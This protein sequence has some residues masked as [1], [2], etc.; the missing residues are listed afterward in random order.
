MIS[1]ATSGTGTITGGIENL[2]VRNTGN[3]D[4]ISVIATSA[5]N[6]ILRNNDIAA[7][8]N[9][10]DFSTTGAPANTLLLSIDGNTLETTGATN[11]AKFVGQII[12]VTDNSIAIRSFAGNKVIGGGAGGGIRFV[13]VRFDSD[14]AGGTVNAGSLDIGTSGAPVNAT[15]LS[16]IS[17]SGTLNLGTLNVFNDAGTGV[18]VDTKGNG[19]IFTLNN[20]GG[21]VS[22]TNGVAFNLDPLTVDMTFASV[23]SV[24]NPAANIANGIIFDGVAGTFT[25]TGATTVTGTSS[26]GIN[27]IN[28]NTGTFN[29]NTVTVNNAATTGG[30]IGWA[31]GTLNVTGLANIDTT[32]GGGVFQEGGST[33]FTGGLTIDTTSGDGFLGIN[34]GSITVSGAGNTITTATGRIVSLQ[35]A[36][37]GAGGMTFDTLKATG[38]VGIGA[39]VQLATVSGGTFNGGALSVAGTS[40]DG[41]AASS[42]PPTIAS[43]QCRHPVHRDQRLPAACAATAPIGIIDALTIRASPA[44]ASRTRPARSTSMAARSAR[45][46]TRPAQPSRLSAAPRP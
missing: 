35:T 9:S 32:S 19:T 25:V 5:S 22:T 10:L 2:I 8:G 39:G 15:G 13:D 36:T 43:G 4:G 31:S 21:V 16:F 38:T 20:T 29:F 24:N 6:F 23:S 41:L 40:I 3:G 33:S 37:I 45:P 46:T 42:Y 18:F 17:A 7:F 1:L 28:T 27:A 44:C 26:F 14:G 30:G 12:S 34:A 11:A